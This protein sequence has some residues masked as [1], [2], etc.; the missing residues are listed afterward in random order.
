MS[1]SS[2]VVAGTNATA[3][4]HNDVRTD[5]ITQFR[6]FY[7]EIKGTIVA[8]TGQAKITVPAGMTV[9]KIKSKL[10]AGTATITVKADATT[11]KSGISVISSYANE[12]SITNPTLT[13]GQELIIDVTAAAG[14][15]T[16]RVLVYAT[17]II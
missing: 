11:V 8:G 5:A 16:L 12:T 1:V 4:Q 17:E 15:D 7:F 10:D 6:R 13:E 2:A 14:A 9:T 3:Q